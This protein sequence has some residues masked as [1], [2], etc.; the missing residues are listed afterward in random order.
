[1]SSCHTAMRRSTCK[2]KQRGGAYGGGVRVSPQD[3]RQESQCFGVLL[4]FDV[5]ED[6]SEALLPQAVLPAQALPLSQ[7]VTNTKT[8]ELSRCHMYCPPA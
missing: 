3:T 6:I 5:S 1:M 7:A 4:C 2:L 8:V